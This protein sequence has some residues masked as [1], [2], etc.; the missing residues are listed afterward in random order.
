[1]SI[2]LQQIVV[3]RHP[4]PSAVHPDESVA[5]MQLKLDLMTLIP[6]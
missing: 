4:P 5:E 3:F 1:M 2:A 6:T